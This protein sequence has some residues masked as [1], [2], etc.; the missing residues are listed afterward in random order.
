MK[1]PELNV[2]PVMSKVALFWLVKSPVWVVVPVTV[3]VA[4]ALLLTEA[5][6]VPSISIAAVLLFWIV[7]VLVSVAA[8]L[9]SI[10]PPLL[11][12]LATDSS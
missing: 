7:P 9:T 5:F 3:K 2:P 4:F 1:L 8:P 12:R 11:S 10:R 6:R